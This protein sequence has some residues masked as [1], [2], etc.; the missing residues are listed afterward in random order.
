MQDDRKRI[1]VID[2]DRD[3]RAFCVTVL[4]GSGYR[5][6]TAPSA[7]EGLALARTWQPDLVILDIMMEAVDS[8]FRVARDLAEERPRM[9]ILMLSSIADAA[10]DLFDATTLPVALLVDKPIGPDF[11]VDT[12]R[13]LLG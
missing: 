1:L 5:V 7:R 10:A 12:V 3:V 6:E 13:R 4:T 9:P 8:G 2:D 11:L